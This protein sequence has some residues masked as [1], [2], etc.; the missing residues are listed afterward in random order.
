MTVSSAPVLFE[1]MYHDFVS[2][3][4]EF[5]QKETE[6]TVNLDETAEIEVTE[7]REGEEQTIKV[8]PNNSWLQTPGTWK[9]VVH[10]F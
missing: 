9:E 5:L 10:V 2:S 8:K 7:W 6:P 4:H 1:K 3:H